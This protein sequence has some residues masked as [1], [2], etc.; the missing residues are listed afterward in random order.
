M[1]AIPYA[2]VLVGFHTP[3]TSTGVTLASS[4]DPPVVC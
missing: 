2:S 1:L 3:S 4:A